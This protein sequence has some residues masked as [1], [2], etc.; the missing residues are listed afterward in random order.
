MW[1]HVQ[2]QLDILANQQQISK[3]LTATAEHMLETAEVLFRAAQ[4]VQRPPGRLRGAWPH[5]VT[6]RL[7]R[8]GPLFTSDADSG[9]NP[10]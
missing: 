4:Q 8:H 5:E 3:E 9:F 6:L 10:A 2:A 7:P 1:Q